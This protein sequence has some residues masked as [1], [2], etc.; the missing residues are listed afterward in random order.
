MNCKLYERQTTAYTVSTAWRVRALVMWRQGSVSHIAYGTMAVR[1][2]QSGLRWDDVCALPKVARLQC[3]QRQSMPCR[4]RASRLHTWTADW[5]GFPHAVLLTI[6]CISIAHF[7]TMQC[8]TIGIVCICS[9]SHSSSGMTP[10]FCRVSCSYL[11]DGE[12]LV[13]QRTLVTW[14]RVSKAI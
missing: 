6:Y 13:W 5:G 7:H 9:S 14:L 11:V 2:G 3:L 10:I 8:S 12:C 1:S 4:A